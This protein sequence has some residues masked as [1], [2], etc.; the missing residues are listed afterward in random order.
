MRAGELTVSGTI[1]YLGIIA[2]VL[3]GFNKGQLL[4]NW[5]G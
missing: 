1:L 2:A 4:G 5:L 3:G